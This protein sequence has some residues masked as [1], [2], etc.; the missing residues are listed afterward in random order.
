MLL[1]DELSAKIAIPSLRA[2][3]GKKLIEAYGMKQESVARLL[4]VTQSAVSNYVRGKRGMTMDLY[5]SETQGMVDDIATMLAKSPA[6]MHDIISK[7]A[8]ACEVLKKKRL[9]CSVHE[10]LEPSLDIDSCHACDS[11]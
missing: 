10:R 4:G 3:V 8:E 6:P 1:P 5:T 11:P 9:M 7:F 2:A